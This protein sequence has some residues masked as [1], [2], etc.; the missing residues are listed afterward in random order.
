MARLT[1]SGLFT[2]PEL[3][4]EHRKAVLLMVS[5]AS[6][7]GLAGQSSRCDPGGRFPAVLQPVDFALYQ[8]SQ[9]G[10]RTLRSGQCR[11]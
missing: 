7:P 10:R 11:R 1:Y 4:L 8:R 3:P 6:V 2:L 9:A 5:A